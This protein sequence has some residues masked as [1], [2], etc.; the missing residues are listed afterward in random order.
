MRMNGL[1]LSNRLLFLRQPLAGHTRNLRVHL[2]RI[3]AGEE[4]NIEFL[5]LTPSGGY[6]HIA[7]CVDAN[8]AARI[9]LFLNQRYADIYFESNPNSGTLSLYPHKHS[10]HVLGRILEIFGSNNYRFFQM[11]SSGS[12]LTF[13][14]DFMEQEKIAASLVR[15]IDLPETHTPF[16]Q[17]ADSDDILQSLNNK[18]ETSAT[19]IES[20]IRTYGIVEK[21]GLFIYHMV[22][23]HAG[24]TE[25]GKS[26][27]RLADAGIKFDF[28]SA[29]A[30]PGGRIFLTIIAG[31]SDQQQL[32]LQQKDAIDGA[33]NGNNFIRPM[34]EAD[35]IYF[36]G[37]HFGDRHGIADRA[38]SAILQNNV[39]IISAGCV[40]ASIFIAVDAQKG[41]DAKNVLGIS[42]DDPFNI[43]DAM[44]K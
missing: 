4:I 18:P 6:P 11:A 30:D 29:A 3:L 24:L 41:I 15:E 44:P 5:N 10:L 13:V 38:F 21:H 42:F 9:D 26:V 28:V 8:E 25:A 7:C 20:S 40:G 16:R 36:Q 2:Y 17:V 43:D 23:D 32:D 19:Y 33:T 22:T 12:M 14:V 27:R 37:P 35:L 34:S 31:A 1:R 39:N